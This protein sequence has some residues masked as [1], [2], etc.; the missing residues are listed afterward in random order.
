[1]RSKAREL[2]PGASAIDAS[3][4]VEL[5]NPDQGIY[6]RQVQHDQPEGR[7]HE[8]RIIQDWQP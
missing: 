2:A 1:M 5:S 8:Q 7:L 6:Q 3:R 4:G